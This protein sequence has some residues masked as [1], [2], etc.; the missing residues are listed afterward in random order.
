[1]IGQ[2]RARDKG[3]VRRSNEKL[4]FAGNLTGFNCTMKAIGLIFLLLAAFSLSA[5]TNQA[6][7]TGQ[8]NQA[9]FCCRH[10]VRMFSNT[11]V[12]LTP[13]FQW[14]M[15][16]EHDG[17]AATNTAGGAVPVRPLAAWQRIT[18]TKTGEIE[19]CWIVNAVVYGSPG[20]RTNERIILKNPPV[21]E[22]RLYYSLKSELPAALQ[23]IAN[24]QRAHQAD[25][26]AAQKAAATAETDSR[27]RNARTRMNA[28]SYSKQAANENAAAAATLNDQQQLEQ[29]HAL[30]EKEFNAIPAVKGKYQIDWFAMEVGVNQQGVPIFDAGGVLDNPP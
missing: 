15:H 8:T 10:P 7:Q 3:F 26:K 17:G 19:S 11:T 9:T 28:D 24:D 12:D 18:G 27:S 25:L 20:V 29:A 23:Q 5:Q 13:L 6:R 30:A 21:A 2:I 1:M 16:H 14:W 22:E 4:N